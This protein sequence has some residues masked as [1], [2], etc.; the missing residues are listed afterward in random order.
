MP[1]LPEGLEAASAMFDLSAPE[2]QQ[3]ASRVTVPL[4]E[5]QTEARNLGLY[6][7]VDDSWKRLSDV[8][9][10]VGRRGGAR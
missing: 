10:I 1:K 2:E 6:S 8:T 3:G 9:L 4:K 5:K 7:Y